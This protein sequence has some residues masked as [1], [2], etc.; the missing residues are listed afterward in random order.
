MFGLISNNI[1][2]IIKPEEVDDLIKEGIIENKDGVIQVQLD[3]LTY[4]IHT[5]NYR[6]LVPDKYGKLICHA[7]NYWKSEENTKHVLIYLP[8]KISKPYIERS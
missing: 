3:G 7:K 4:L 2:D 1:I 5:Y 6:C 8:K